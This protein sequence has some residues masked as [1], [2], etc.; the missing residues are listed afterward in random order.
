[1]KQVTISRGRSLAANGR[2]CADGMCFPE[3]DDNTAQHDAI[4]AR[5]EITAQQF[6]ARLQEVLAEECRVE[7]FSANW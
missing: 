2:N 7:L 3:D 1:M 5:D 6:A 4:I